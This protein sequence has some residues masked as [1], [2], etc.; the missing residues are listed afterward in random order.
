V[1]TADDGEAVV[2]VR[3]LRSD[4]RHVYRVGRDGAV[5]ARA[6]LAGPALNMGPT[7]VANVDGVY[8][9]LRDELPGA[10]NGFTHLLRLDRKTLALQRIAVLPGYVQLHLDGPR[11]LT[12]AVACDAFVVTRVDPRTLRT[13]AVH[14]LSLDSTSV[15]QVAFAAGR[16]LVAYKKRFEDDEVVVEGYALT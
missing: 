7:V 14:D 10:T 4:V 9:G 8:V 12:D 13:A 5:L 15:H 3:P 2:V 11:V 16:A 1:L 6:V